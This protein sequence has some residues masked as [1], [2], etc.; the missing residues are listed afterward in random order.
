MFRPPNE[1]VLCFEKPSAH[2]EA[3]KFYF[4]TEKACY[5]NSES[6]S[7]SVSAN[8]IGV[9]TKLSKFIFNLQ[10]KIG[11]GARTISSASYSKLKVPPPIN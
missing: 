1:C 2:C 9:D 4:G 3:A 6:C 7:E 5:P 8:A 11:T 10:V